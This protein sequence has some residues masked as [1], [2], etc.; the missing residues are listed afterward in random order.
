M[1]RLIPQLKQV[2][3]LSKLNGLTLLETEEEHHHGHH[4]EHHDDAH[5][6]HDAHQDA[7]KFLDPHL[8]RRPA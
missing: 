3:V 4:D 2:R 8:W 5:D 7:D 1:T 6:D